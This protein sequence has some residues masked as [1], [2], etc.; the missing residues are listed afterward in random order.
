MHK[1]L[2]SVVV[3]RLT[4]ASWQALHVPSGRKVVASTMAE[5]ESLMLRELGL[6]DEGTFTDPPT[7]QRFSGLAQAIA[8]FLEGAISD[9]LSFHAGFARLEAFEFG[10]AHI[11]LGGGCKGCPSSQLTLFNGVR[12]Q[13][14]G[15][16][17]EDVVKDVVLAEQEP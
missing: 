13:L 11:R 17:G 12:D 1:E 6:S 2:I 14:Q 8:L 15:R 3:S 10:I 7:S 9:S 16:F 5:A 4:E